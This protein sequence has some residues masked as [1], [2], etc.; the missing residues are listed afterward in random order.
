MALTCPSDLGDVDLGFDEFVDCSTVSINYDVMGQATV[1]FTVVASQSVP[2]DPNVYTTMIFGGVQFKGHITSLEIKRIEG[3]IVYE[4]R[5]T[6]A[7]VGC[8][9]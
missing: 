1:S 2:I 7:A 4:H 8:R 6:I 9:I 5:Y 3:T